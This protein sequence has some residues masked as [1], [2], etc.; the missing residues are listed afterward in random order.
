MGNAKEMWKEFEKFNGMKLRDFRGES[1]LQ[2][3][4]ARRRQAWNGERAHDRRW[5]QM[6]LRWASSPQR[7]V[8]R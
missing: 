6:G 5:D 2:S 7:E 8:H 1:H 4:M 3:R